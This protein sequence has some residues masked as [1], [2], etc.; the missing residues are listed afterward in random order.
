MLEQRAAEF[1]G[2]KA[3]VLNTHGKSEIGENDVNT[4]VIVMCVV[5]PDSVA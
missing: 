3:N 1:Q 4:T 2:G 5:G